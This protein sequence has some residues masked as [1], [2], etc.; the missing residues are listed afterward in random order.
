MRTL[1]LVVLV[2]F[3]MVMFIWLLALLG[4][5]SDLVHISSW[6]PWFACLLLGIGTGAYYY[7][8]RPPGA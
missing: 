3:I 6:L 8:G 2:L 1:G 7:N 5:V 4:A